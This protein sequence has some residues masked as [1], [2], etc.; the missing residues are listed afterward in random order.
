MLVEFSRNL[1]RGHTPSLSLFRAILSNRSVDVT[2]P[3]EGNG[4]W[5][6]LQLQPERRMMEDMNP[7]QAGSEEYPAGK[8][9]PLR[10]STRQPSPRVAEWQGKRERC[11]RERMRFRSERERASEPS[12]RGQRE[13]VHDFERGQNYEPAPLFSLPGPPPVPLGSRWPTQTVSFSS[14]RRANRGRKSTFQP[15]NASPDWVEY[16]HRS[17]CVTSGLRNGLRFPSWPLWQGIF[18]G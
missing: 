1:R 8:S 16:G 15:Q 6:L 2:P 3:S 17:T 11:E 14:R 12:N 5:C 9:P 7:A 18:A 4:G 13:V 10:R